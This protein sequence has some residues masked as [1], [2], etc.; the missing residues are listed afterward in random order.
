MN[1]L[2]IRQDTKLE[3][4]IHLLPDGITIDADNVTLDGQGATIIGVNKTGAGLKASGR[5][6]ITIKSLCILNYYHGISIKKS[7]GVA[8]SNCTITSTGEVPANTLFLDIWKPT[9]HRSKR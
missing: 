3:P 6:N 4:G 7:R 2:V 9:N 8:I 5:R 1:G